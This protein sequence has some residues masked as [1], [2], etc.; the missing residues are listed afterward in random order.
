MNKLMLPPPRLSTGFYN[1]LATRRRLAVR[2][3]H[4]TTSLWFCCRQRH[5]RTAADSGNDHATALGGGMRCIPSALPS[6]VLAFVLASGL[7]Q[8]VTLPL[9]RPSRADACQVHDCPTT[10]GSCVFGVL[11][12]KGKRGPAGFGTSAPAI[13]VPSSAARF[14]S[15]QSCDHRISP[16]FRF[17]YLGTRTNFLFGRWP[18]PLADSECLASVRLM[19]SIRR[20]HISQVHAYHRSLR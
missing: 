18:R 15:L 9:R 7:L 16:T 20:A 10:R 17:W 5:G 3:R 8:S 6:F 11:G 12:Y 4:H 2:H 19:P 13:T 14:L 1:N